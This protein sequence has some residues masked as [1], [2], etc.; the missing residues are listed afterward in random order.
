M[1]KFPTACPSCK[2]PGGFCLHKPAIPAHVAKLG[3]EVARALKCPTQLAEMWRCARCG[4]QFDRLTK[5]A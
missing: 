5:T 2:G 4:S 1:K 3:F